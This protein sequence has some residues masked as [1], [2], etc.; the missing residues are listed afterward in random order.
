[1][2]ESRYPRWPVWLCMTMTIWL[3]AATVSADPGTRIIAHR[4][5][6]AHLP[7]HTREAYLL[8]YGMGADFLEPDLVMT[9]DGALISLHDATLEATTDVAQ[10]FPTRDRGDGRFYAM[11]FTLAEIRSLNF[12]ERVEPDSGLARYPA[13]WPVGQGRFQPVTLAEL[14]KLVTRLNRTT[15]RAVGI[16]PEIKF[17][18]LH[19]EA[20]HDITAAVVEELLAHELPRADLPVFIQCFEPEPLVRIRREHGDRFALVQL[21]GEN[22]WA[23]NEVDYDA[24]RTPEGLSAIARYADAIGPPI[25]RLVPTDSADRALLERARANGLAVHPYT[26]R[27][28]SM[29]PGVTLERML[30]LF[31]HDLKIDALFTDH[32]DIALAVRAAAA[33]K[34]NDP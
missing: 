11:D 7:E 24:M 16:Y 30:A 6:S 29:P 14:I 12:N 15:G 19:R 31:I 13:R 10:R 3:A 32:P 27:R 9:A 26:F 33:V 17:P 21:I 2:N 18:S 4:G 22:D 20:G 23:M 28:E 1:M 5:A 34:R 8:A 25:A